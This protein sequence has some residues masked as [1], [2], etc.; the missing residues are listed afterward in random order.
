[1]TNFTRAGAAAIPMDPAD[2]QARLGDVFSDRAID[3]GMFRTVAYV[4]RAPCG[5]G[6]WLCMLSGSMIP[7][8]SS[9]EAPA[10][11][12]DSLYSAPRILTLTQVEDLVTLCAFEHAQRASIAD[13]F[14]PWHCFLIGLR[15]EN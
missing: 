8:S 15:V 1:M 13:Y 12:C 11:L 7:G 4:I 2:I 10:M 9:E 6:R 3:E 14:C 5:G